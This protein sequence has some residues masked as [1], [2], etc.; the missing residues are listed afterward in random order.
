MKAWIADGKRPV[1]IANP[2]NI[3]TWVEREKARYWTPDDEQ[4]LTEMVAHS[5]SHADIAVH[6]G[7]SVSG[8]VS[9]MYKMRNR[10]GE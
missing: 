5:M 4:L 3:M 7:R 8:V 10:H 6:L 9:K 2:N 1:E